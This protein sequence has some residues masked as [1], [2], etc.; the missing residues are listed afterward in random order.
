MSESSP[1]EQRVASSA[2]ESHGPDRTLVQ[3]ADW[4]TEQAPL[5]DA[6]FS[7][8]ATLQAVRIVERLTGQH[9]LAEGEMITPAVR[10]EYVLADGQT[11]NELKSMAARR[12]GVAVD[13]SGAGIRARC[14]I[15]DEVFFHEVYEIVM[16]RDGSCSGTIRYW[17]FDVSLRAGKNSHDELVE[18]RF[19]WNRRGSV[20]KGE[21]IELRLC[22]PYLLR[23]LEGPEDEKRA[24]IENPSSIYAHPETLPYEEE[25]FRSL[26][27]MRR[28]P[29]R[30]A[31]ETPFII[32]TYVG[33][34]PAV[35]AGGPPPRPWRRPPP[36]PI[37]TA[38]IPPS[39]ALPEVAW[40]ATAWLGDRF[41]PSFKREGR[42]E[43]GPAE[44]RFEKYIKVRTIP[45]VFR[46]TQSS[47]HRFIPDVLQ[48]EN[49]VRLVSQRFRDLIEAFE[50]G[51]HKFIEVDVF[52]RSGAP[53]PNKYYYL[54]I[55][56]TI[57]VVT[58]GQDGAR[59][60]GALVRRGTEAYRDT[61]LTI[62]VDMIKGKHLWRV[63]KYKLDSRM[64]FSDVLKQA[65][66]ATRIKRLSYEYVE[67]S[68]GD[69]M[70]R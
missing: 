35:R 7:E 70:R 45:A 40:A 36:I 4:L 38:P 21:Q 39:T 62:A 50:P 57:E 34:N 27:R 13:A 12:L 53:V 17:C 69:A 60:N 58:G 66:E 52:D 43:I 11:V 44:K 22:G 51:V 18:Q 23:F 29:D 67:C 61:G 26:F 65:V 49:P 9:P 42:K 64:F 5:F 2:E 59:K 3:L 63:E 8:V 55:T 54:E 68:A 20:Y 14:V 24:L 31:I 1:S 6:L 32:L 37:G 15:T 19:A 47:L 30:I 28:D 56:Q 33:E 25:G 41:C 10:F 16:Q 46:Q 48:F